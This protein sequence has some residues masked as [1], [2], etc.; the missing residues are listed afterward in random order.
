M[1]GP[2]MNKRMEMVLAPS[3]SSDA[4]IT[5]ISGVLRS[6]RLAAGSRRLSRITTPL[7]ATS[8]PLVKRG[9][10]TDQARLR[11][12][13]RPVEL[14]GEERRVVHR[15]ALGEKNTAASR[16]ARRR[17][18]QSAK[19]C[20]GYSAGG[21]GSD[22]RSTKM[23]AATISAC[24]SRYWTRRDVCS[25][26]RSRPGNSGCASSASFTAVSGL[27]G[28]PRTPPRPGYGPRACGRCS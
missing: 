23:H 20:D 22:C 7:T 2:Q 3:R 24:S 18:R 26:R 4:G 17:A 15:M 11:L 13:G 21:A 5:A 12:I 6:G 10:N 19:R 27:A 1:I 28:P 14:P 25:R 8:T 9:R 16:G